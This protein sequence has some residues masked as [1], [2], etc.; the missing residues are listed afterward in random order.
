M[1]LFSHDTSSSKAVSGEE[2]VRSA[3]PGGRVLWEV[4]VL[5][6]QVLCRLRAKFATESLL[7]ILRVDL[8]QR[9]CSPEGFSS[10]QNFYCRGKGGLCGW[11]YS[12]LVIVWPSLFH[13]MVTPEIATALLRLLDT[14]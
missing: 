5:T 3:D 14:P 6:V 9:A 10:P 13:G 1:C 12:G 11:G 2:E 7:S 8:L 4:T